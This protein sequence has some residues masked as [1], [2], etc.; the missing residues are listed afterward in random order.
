MSLFSFSMLQV[1]IMIGSSLF[2]LLCSHTHVESFMRAVLFL[3]AASLCV[4]V[5]TPQVRSKTKMKAFLRSIH[6]SIALCCSAR[7][8]IAFYCN[9]TQLTSLKIR[10]M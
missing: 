3:A 1:A 6:S 9:P 5:F 10:L 7:I 2:K 8:L 4:P